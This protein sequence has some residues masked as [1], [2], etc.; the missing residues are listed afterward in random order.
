MQEVKKVFLSL[1]LV[2]TM[3]FG[4]GMI[5]SNQIHPDAETQV[6]SFEQGRNRALEL[7][8]RENIPSARRTEEAYMR[9]MSNQG[10]YT[11]LIGQF[12]DFQN[13]SIAYYRERGA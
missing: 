5:P 13:G 3:I 1:V 8:Q 2:T 6:Q 4:M 10:F 7:S 12:P 11:S 9:A